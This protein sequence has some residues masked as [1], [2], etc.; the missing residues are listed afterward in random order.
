MSAVSTRVTVEEFLALPEDESV[1]QELINGEVIT[2]ARAGQPHEI[3]KSNFTQEL[4]VYFKA[5]PIG[6]ALPE[7]AF[8]LSPHDS[9]IPDVSIVLEGRLNPVHTGLISL[10][11]DL[12]V[13]VVSSESAA[14]LQAKVKLY[15]GHGARAVWVAYPELRLVYV[16]DKS[17][18]RE[19]AGEE[20]LEAPG[21]LP[22]F[23]IPASAFF[24]GL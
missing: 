2:M 18:V 11:P 8:R 21:L 6:R 9:P 20:H 7:T 3:V 15:L 22:G 1:R 4:A 13:E 10:C 12:A 5:H 17:G 14:F 16:Y 24:V 23:S 19:V